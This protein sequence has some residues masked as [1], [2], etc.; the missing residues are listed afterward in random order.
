MESRFSIPL[1]V[2]ETKICS[3]NRGVL[4]IEGK[5]VV[6]DLRP[7]YAR[8]FFLQLATQRWRMK[9]IASC[10]G[11]VSRSNL[12]RNVAKSRIVILLFLQLAT[13]PHFF[14]LQVAKMGCCTGNCF[15]K[16]VALQV[17][18]KIASCNMAFKRE[19][20]F[21]REF[22]KLEA[23]RNLDFTVLIKEALLIWKSGIKAIENERLSMKA[24]VYT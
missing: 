11:H 20:E 14:A 21:M 15:R 13:Q 10:A 2:R 8:Q 22:R 17:A 19:N 23:S 12:S 16:L 18:G 24:N 9:T 3:K 5:N 7:C 6:F 1:G 4:E